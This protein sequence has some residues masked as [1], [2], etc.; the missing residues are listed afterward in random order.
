MSANAAANAAIA[1]AA[2]CTLCGPAFAKPTIQTID[3]PGESST[4]LDAINDAGVIAGT[5]TDNAGSHGVILAADGS[6]TIF[7]PPGSTFSTVTG[8]NAAGDIVGY[9]EP[10]NQVECFIRSAAGGFTL[11]K[12]PQNTNPYCTAYAINDKGDVVGAEEHGGA[13]ANGWAFLLTPSGNLR[14]FVKE[15]QKS[16]TSFATGINNAKTVVGFTL[17]NFGQEVGFVRTRDGAI[18]TFSAPGAYY[19]TYA[20]AINAKGIV[21]GSYADKTGFSHGLVRSPDGTLTLFD[22]EGSATSNT[23][24]EAI[25]GRGEI[26]GG[27][28]Y[29][30]FFRS[31]NG[32]I[33]TFVPPDASNTYPTSLNASGVIVGVYVDSHGLRHGFILTP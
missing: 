33:T 10:T 4:E 22:V 13:H 14:K 7:D 26:T 27:S 23:E 29:G 18:T 25:N 32:D 12:P 15:G 24:P 2:L 19:G 3:V 16:G 8:M 30:G 9:T 17:E 11:F 21:A 20:S 28:A 1:I 5:V 6:F 31:A